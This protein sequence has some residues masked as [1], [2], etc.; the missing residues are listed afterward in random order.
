ME[1]YDKG[2]ETFQCFRLSE[3][4][5]LKKKLLPIIADIE[6]QYIKTKGMKREEDGQIRAPALKF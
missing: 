3:D 6:H 2:L 4:M 1:L 5:S